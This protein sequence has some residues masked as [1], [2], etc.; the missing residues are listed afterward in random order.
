MAL[1]KIQYNIIYI[2]HTYEMSKAV[3]KHYKSDQCSIIKV[4]SDSMSVYIVQ[5]SLRYRVE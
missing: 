3:C 4:A 5:Q 2:V 1:T